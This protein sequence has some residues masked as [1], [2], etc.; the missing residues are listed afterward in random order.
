MWRFRADFASFSLPALAL[1]IIILGSSG[2]S[3]A[4]GAPGTCPVGGYAITACPV[5]SD[6]VIRDQIVSRLSGSVASARYPVT[7]VV[8]DGVA[9][10]RGMVQTAGKR[11]LA[12]LFAFGVRGVVGVYNQLS[13]DPALADDLL[14]VGEV[15]K[16]FN[17]SYLDSKQVNVNVSEG[18]VQL[19][20]QVTMEIDR[21]QATQIAASVPGVAAVYNNISVRGPSGSPF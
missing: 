9:T 5:A 21:E 16:A 8:C 7:V 12:T 13:V 1:A 6:N 4:Q 11:D 20:G 14:L 18:V 2:A 10:I 3:L 19:T 15:R 17:K